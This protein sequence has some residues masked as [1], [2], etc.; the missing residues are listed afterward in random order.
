MP[1]PELFERSAPA[2][3]GALMLEH[4]RAEAP[5]PRH[6]GP[7]ATEASLRARLADA[8][9]GGDEATEREISVSLARL[10]A[11]RG[12]DLGAAA[13]LAQRA[14]DIADD[15]LLRVEL[16]GWLAGLG[17]T[18]AAA[19]TLRVLLPVDKPAEAARTTVKIAVLLA[20]A[21]DAAG[22]AEALDEAA[23]LDEAEAMAVELFG[24]LTAWAPETVTPEGAAAAYLEASRRRSPSVGTGDA[25]AAYEDLLRAFEVAPHDAAAA[26][27]VAEALTARGL[28]GAADEVLRLSVEAAVELVNGAPADPSA[29]SAVH[30]RR[31]LTALEDGDAARAVGAMLDGGL[32]GELEGEGAARV[33]EALALAGL[34]E[35][36]AVR[37]EARAERLSGAPRSEAYQ[38]LARLCAGPLASQDRAVEAW[39]EALASDPGGVVGA[40]ARAALRDHAAAMHDPAPLAE[41]LIRAGSGAGALPA[42]ERAAALRELAALADDRMADPGLASWALDALAALDVPGHEGDLVNAEKLGLLSRLARQDEELAAARRALDAAASC[43]RAGASR[44]T[45]RA[46]QGAAPRDRGVPGAARRDRRVRDGAGRAGAGRAGGS[47]RPRRAG[48]RVEAIGEAGRARGGAPRS[49]ARRDAAH[50][51]GAGAP[52]A[53]GDC[54]ASRRRGGR[55]R[56]SA[57]GARRERCRGTARPR[58]RR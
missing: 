2:S 41:A 35:L 14:L 6:S 12:R 52:G 3:V 30:L 36:L 37:L 31:M 43:A 22:A 56:G 5:M 9:E 1:P 28:P 16:A 45:T 48:A 24:T 20:R 18:A 54:A 49:G 26:E 7:R 47:I 8:R 40:A 10:L 13:A 38:A 21:G 32:E 42:T 55:A 4:L 29:V 17:E 53:L 39:I 15:S 33:D 50:R 44:G 46:A 57:P 34:Y 27:A 11:A 19:A 58:A 23:S 51:S 25:E